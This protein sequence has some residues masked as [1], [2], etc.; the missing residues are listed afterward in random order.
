[1]HNEEMH[2]QT[3]TAIAAR[4]AELAASG[5][6]HAR[7]WW[8]LQLG[9]WLGWASPYMGN[10]VLAGA[11]VAAV[12]QHPT[13]FRPDGE[14]AAAQRSVQ[15]AT[16][17]ERLH[18]AQNLVAALGLDPLASVPSRCIAAW[19]RVPAAMPQMP[20][21]VAAA[22]LNW[23]VIRTLTVLADADGASPDRAGLVDT[24]LAQLACEAARRSAGGDH[25]WAGIGLVDH[26][27]GGDDA[28]TRTARLALSPRDLMMVRAEL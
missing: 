24:A 26:R 16:D 2:A 15:E 22:Q 12:Q 14:V 9:D 27:F 19:R 25:R 18:A 21:V 7:W 5:E 10:V 20:A 13:L 17:H 28:V 4:A 1:M 23:L 3:L 8:E 6:P 11:L